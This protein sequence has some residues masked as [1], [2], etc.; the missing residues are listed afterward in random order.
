MWS[1]PK[2]IGQYVTLFGG[3]VMEKLSNIRAI[4]FGGSESDAAVG[5]DV[6]ILNISILINTVVRIV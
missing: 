4:V 6:F 3:F 1:N 2:V 5:S